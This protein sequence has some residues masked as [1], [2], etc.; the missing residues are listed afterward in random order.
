NPLAVDSLVERDTTSQRLYAEHDANG[1]ATS[2]VDTS[3]NVQERYVYDPYG[4]ITV[5]T[6][7]WSVQ[8]GG[9]SFGWVYLFQ[10]GRYDATSILY[11]FRNRYLSS[12]LGGWVQKDP[13]GL[14][15]G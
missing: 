8:S 4:A 5:L 13:V 1:D 14:H 9:S 2:V 10:G 7:T 15:A 6:P 12:I 3:A 11:N